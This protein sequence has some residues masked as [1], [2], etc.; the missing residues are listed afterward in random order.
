MYPLMHPA[1]TAPLRRASVGT[2]LSGRSS[3]Y[4]RGWN[5]GRPW[6]PTAARGGEAHAGPPGVWQFRR[7]RDR[8]RPSLWIREARRNVPDSDRTP[9]IR[10]KKVETIETG[11]D[12]SKMNQTSQSCAAQRTPRTPCR[13][14]AVVTRWS[15]R[16]LHQIMSGSMPLCWHVETRSGL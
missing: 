2:R 13:I 5:R 4:G 11:F 10:A 7:R 3:P 8:G 14:A 1:M 12:R 16:G 6:K 15:L 9:R